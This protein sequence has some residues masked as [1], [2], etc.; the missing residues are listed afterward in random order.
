MAAAAAFINDTTCYQGDTESNDSES[1]EFITYEINDTSLQ[2]EVTVTTD[3]IFNEAHQLANKKHYDQAIEALDR[4]NNERASDS[5]TLARL[6]ILKAEYLFCKLKKEYPIFKN[7]KKCCSLLQSYKTQYKVASETM[8]L[9]KVTK[10]QLRD[11]CALV[12]K[13]TAGMNEDDYYL[14]QAIVLQNQAVQIFKQFTV[15]T[16]VEQDQLEAL[17]SE[18]ALLFTQHSRFAK[19]LGQGLS[20]CKDMREALQYRSVL[21]AKIGRKREAEGS[22][23]Y[24]ANHTSWSA[25]SSQTSIPPRFQ[26]KTTELRVERRQQVVFVQPVQP[27]SGDDSLNVSKLQ[28]SINDSSVELERLYKTLESLD[29][30]DYLH[31]TLPHSSSR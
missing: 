4:L 24:S 10:D 31:E 5:L 13:V 11:G 1:D 26:N 18:L 29:D 8:R 3:D 27:G 14:R 22:K 28:K 30:L 12:N 17:H 9:P 16:V 19:I 23:A 2:E 20:M 21:M 15:G 7:L 6:S 25:Y